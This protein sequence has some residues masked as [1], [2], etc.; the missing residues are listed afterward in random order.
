MTPS[1]ARRFAL[2]HLS[3]WERSALTAVLIAAVVVRIIGLR[4]GLPGAA[5]LSPDENTVVPKTLAMIH[6]GT[7]NPHW[8]LYPSLYLGLLGLRLR[9]TPSGLHC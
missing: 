1:T 7:A 6:D 8:F 4:A 3:R 2:W 9:Q 5:L